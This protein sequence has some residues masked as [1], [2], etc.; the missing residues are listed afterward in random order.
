[1]LR[2][3][4]KTTIKSSTLEFEGL[5]LSTQEYAITFKEFCRVF[6]NDSVHTTAELKQISGI[7]CHPIQ[8]ISDL[9]ELK[10]NEMQ[11]FPLDVAVKLI[12]ALA[13]KGYSK[14]MAF[15]QEPFTKG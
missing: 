12:C 14:C 4:A 5:M 9:E 8:V 3:I 1:M 10:G 11:I 13:Q 6:L 2:I 15:A 7:A